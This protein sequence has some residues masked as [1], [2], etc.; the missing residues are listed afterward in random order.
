MIFSLIKERIYTL[1]TRWYKIAL[2]L[3]IPALFIAADIFKDATGAYELS[4]VIVDEDN[5]ELSSLVTERIKSST[6]VSLK[7]LDDPFNALM[8]LEITAVFVIK[9]GFADKIAEGIFEETVSVYYIKGDVTAQIAS[10]IFAKEVMRIFISE[11]SLDHIGRTY[12][13]H[14]QVFTDAKRSEASDF[15]E[16]FWSRGL[17]LPV[18]YSVA[19]TVSQSQISL[20]D[21]VID[22][23]FLLAVFALF[24]V[25]SADMI[26]QRDYGI[27]RRLRFLNF[28]V[29]KYVL[30]AS[31]TDAAVYIPLLFAVTDEWL[32]YSLLFIWFG[33]I[34]AIVTV[35]VRKGDL[36]YAAAI[37]SSVMVVTGAAAFFYGNAAKWIKYLRWLNVFYYAMLGR[38]S[39]ADAWLMLCVNILIALIIYTV[40]VNV[41]LSKKR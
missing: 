17:T 3:F 29:K 24:L 4:A 30:A 37:L 9:E 22:T 36:P 13:R 16:G 2:F 35:T 23:V 19:H 14:G 26:L 18:S 40:C 12:E 11:T 39:H 10:E 34:N 20:R 8:G 31:V 33:I 38:H 7:D 15:I 6:G 32:L 5:T 25:L 41:R 1:R 28:P 27:F 21:I